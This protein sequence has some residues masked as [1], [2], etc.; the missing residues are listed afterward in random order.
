MVM[1][2]TNWVTVRALKVTRQCNKGRANLNEMSHGLADDFKWSTNWSRTR[3][4]VEEEEEEE[5]EKE[6][7]EER[8]R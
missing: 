5:E 4:E 8:V 2:E 6:K 7:E 3:K 1:K